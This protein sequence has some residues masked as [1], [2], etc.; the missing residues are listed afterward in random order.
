[1]VHHLSRMPRW[2]RKLREWSARYVP[3]EIAGTIC[4]VGG[5][6]VA[7]QLSGDRR[8]AA[9]A[10]TVAENVGFYGVILG[11]EWRHQRLHSRADALRIALRT[12]R[13]T[14]AEF[15]PAELV[16]LVARPVS[17]YVATLATGHIAGGALLGKFM[18]DAVFYAVAIVGYEVAS[19]RSRTDGAHAESAQPPELIVGQPAAA[20]TP[21]TAATAA[22]AASAADQLRQ[23]A[24]NSSGTPV[25]VMDLDLVAE[26]YRALTRAMPG[27]GVYFAVKCN[28]YQPVLAR[29][30]ELGSKFEIA[31]A[32]ELDELLAVGVQPA[33]VLFS[34][35]VKPKAHIAYAYAIGVRHFAAD[36]PEE[37]AKLVQLAPG[38]RVI[39]RLATRRTRSMVPSEGKFGVDAETV[40]E[41]LLSARDH[42]LSPYG[43]A[44]HV[45]SQMMSP[46]A[47]RDPLER[48][49]EVMEKLAADNVFLEMVNLGGGFPASY[50]GTE[51]P[52]L[53]EYGAV[54]AAGLAALPY[55]V[56]A[57]VEP[58]RALVAAAGTLVATVI[59]TAVRG[60]ARWVH[61]DVGAFNGLMES[62]ETNNTLRFPVADSL[63]ADVRE[64]CHLTGPT[65]DSQDTILFDVE[66]SAGLSAGHRVYI[67]SA[68]AYTTVYAS[69][70]NGFAVPAV[71]C[72]DEWAE[73]RR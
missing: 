41:L 60:G 27:V 10:A 22:T 51:P 2:L 71:R 55:P 12:L 63:F 42:G 11:V 50:T 23:A 72:V 45:G 68:G 62:L 16:D 39:A 14:I 66:M 17:I 35:P 18:A 44:F 48:V 37:L 34:N 61:L 54:I 38:S 67:G 32:A 9:V 46:Q 28:P 33:D 5:A 57:V 56:R 47:W 70:F 13:A 73:A 24:D 31:S 58:G 52:P 26:A 1:V 7:F 69:R 6:F 8:I 25:L 20:S 21:T 29:L 19:R 53:T 15:G 4:A 43:V 59:G 40:A 64:K 3:A 36:S 49:G 65:C 30:S